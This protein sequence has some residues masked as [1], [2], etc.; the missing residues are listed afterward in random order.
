MHV[1]MAYAGQWGS[2][3]HTSPQFMV[4]VLDML[5]AH[6]DTP[7]GMHMD[8]HGTLDLQ[9]TTCQSA[10]CQLVKLQALGQ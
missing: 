5:A 3:T 8:Q 4:F 2:I 7:P 9:E 1:G 10:L 6:Q